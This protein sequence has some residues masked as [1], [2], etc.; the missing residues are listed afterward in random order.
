[1]AERAISIKLSVKDQ[2]QVL[3]ALRAVGKEGE[4]M[5]GRLEASSKKAAVETSTL[6]KAGTAT[7]A[8]LGQLKS[9]ILELTGQLGGMAPLLSQSTLLF[10]GVAAAVGALAAGFV[11][12]F[13]RAK[14]AA[15]WAED[16][17]KFA[18]ALDSSVREVQ[19]LE[20]AAR[21]LNVETATFREGMKSLQL[22]VF[23]ASA[24]M[25]EAKA[26]FKQLGIEARDANG[27]VKPTLVI[28]K[29]LAA[30]LQQFDRAE[31]LTIMRRVFGGTELAPLLKDGPE[32]LRSMIE[33][34]E[35]LGVVMDEGPLKAAAET[36]KHIREIENLTSTKL[37]NAFAEISPV[38][39]GVKIIAHEILTVIVKM[40]EAMFKISGISAAFQEIV[41]RAQIGEVGRFDEDIA[42]ARK[43]V[44]ALRES[45]ERNRQAKLPYKDISAAAEAGVRELE[46]LQ[47]RRA[48]VLKKIEADTKRGEK[49]DGP[50]EV[51]RRLTDPEA[52]KKGVAAHEQALKE[53][54]KLENDAARKAADDRFQ[55]IDVQ[56]AQELDK[57][58]KLLADKVIGEQEYARVSEAI[59]KKNQ[60]E[61][62][63]I[64]R[65]AL[66]KWVDD[67]IKAHERAAEEAMKP[68]RKFG[69]DLAGELADA[70]QNGFK[71]DR[72]NIERSIFRLAGGT[73]NT[74]L[75]NPLL[76]GLGLA[77][78]MAGSET[79]PL[80][81]LGR[82][83][84]SGATLFG[85]PIFGG[86]SGSAG[87]QELVTRA[88]ISAGQ[89]VPSGQ[90]LLQGT[91]GGAA[92]GFS[93][94]S[95]IPSLF[96]GTFNG[97]NSQIGGTI[98]GG[99]GA[100][101]GSIIPGI[102]TMIGGLVGS[103][104]GSI[105]GGLFGP[106]KPSVGPN[107]GGPIDINPSTGQ[108][109]AHGF[110]AD[111]GGSVNDAMA[112]GQA[113]SEAINRFTKETGTTVRA[114]GGF[115][116]RTF[117]GRFETG[118]GAGTLA[119]GADAEQVIK[120]SLFGL[121]KRGDI[122]AGFG[123]GAAKAIANSV[124]TDIEGLLADIEFG[125][126]LAD[127]IDGLEATED[128]LK[129]VEVAAR[130]AAEEQAKAI[131]GFVDKAKGLGFNSEAG[132]ALTKLV[133]QL[134][135]F[136][137]APEQLTETAKALAALA[138]NFDVLRDN[139]EALGLTE[140]RIAAA[141]ADARDELRKGFD[142]GVA[143]QLLAITDP[144]AAAL[145]DFDKV[146][147][148]RLEEARQAGA[149]IVGVEKLNAAQRLAVIE[150][151]SNAS[152]SSL[153]KFYEEVLFGQTGGA[154]PG[155][156]LS[157]SAAAFQAA[158]AQA[159]AGDGAARGRLAEL[160]QGFL[161]SSRAFFGSSAGFQ[162]DRQFV[163][164]ALAPF[165]GLN[166]NPIVAAVNES[167]AEGLRVWNKILDELAALR[168]TTVNQAADIASLNAR[169]ARA[170]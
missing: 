151:A 103:T 134:L 36:N 31:R 124:A 154:S 118:F 24:G 6:G 117:S 142:E 140:A 17:L 149:D 43:G 107:A 65:A 104:F 76:S 25:G 162:Q 39:L 156:A 16:T 73:A 61:K 165:V 170:A 116:A 77:T 113:V 15:Q 148:Q 60:A 35:R 9:P 70:I 161:E 94:G 10:G 138:A 66:D 100:A 83:F 88:A 64:S 80:F 122:F 13:N 38:L 3:A 108:V 115:A 84:S 133:D 96:P 150:Q 131:T 114:I 54:E 26:V 1:M 58:Q 23:E 166:D 71:V 120:Q 152:L 72:A 87:E 86:L 53:I 164:D 18:K 27:N 129:A 51:T 37:R 102:G 33:N 82:S 143:R 136:S 155:Q 157:G 40:A 153:Q 28:F 126:N 109:Y 59:W 97:Q 21:N 139:A 75:L 99:I 56:S 123:E 45:A 135:D 42:A 163:L 5:A 141:E 30:V 128:Q 98:G 158:V 14:E 44:D 12:L 63:E 46:E 95:I 89:P 19:A 69:D 119:A 105:F 121:V 132:T 8:A 85:Q 22:R 29:E 92:T 167:S 79:S 55:R 168:A 4:T 159:S 81:N 50:P 144:L 147:A 146:A 127:I 111:N 145:A 67:Q 57:F 68:W 48:A 49:Y 7:A 101:V 41:R 93:I 47:R 130:K 34:A 110:N 169:Q 11:I 91:L 52:L 62:D 112:F 137:T 90:G 106:K 2:E 74:Q 78:P 20:F 160:G 32:G 125:R